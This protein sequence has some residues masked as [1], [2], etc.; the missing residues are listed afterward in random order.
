MICYWQALFQWLLRLDFPF[1]FWVILT[2]HLIV[3]LHFSFFVTW[4]HGKLLL[5]IRRKQVFFSLQHVLV[6][7]GMTLQLSI[8]GYFSFF[9]QWRFLVMLFLIRTHHY[10]CH[11][12]LRTVKTALLRGIFRNRGH[13]ICPGCCSHT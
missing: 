8:L 11:S 7:Q 9:I 4:V 1:A 12:S 10:V 2:N 5:G 6:Q 13:L 3:C